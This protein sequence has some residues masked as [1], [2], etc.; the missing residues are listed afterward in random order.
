[1]AGRTRFLIVGA[2]Q[3]GRLVGEIVSRLPQ[4]ECVGYL[5]RDPALHGRSFYG[6]PVLGGEEL[7]EAHAG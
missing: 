6:I 3:T 7:L 1:V 5:D 2:G 4:L